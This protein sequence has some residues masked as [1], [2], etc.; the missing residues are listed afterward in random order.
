MNGRAFT[1][2]ETMLAALIGALVLA[3]CMGMF[4]LLDRS[5]RRLGA[6]YE[7]AMAMERLRGAVAR[8]MDTL[9]MSTDPLPPSGGR[10][11]TEMGQPSDGPPPP[12]PR[13]VL[14]PDAAASLVGVARRARIAGEGATEA[15]QRFEVVLSRS[16]LPV[17]EA[18]DIPAHE[19]RAVRGVFE[20][21]PDRRANLPSYRVK[22]EQPGWTLWWR[23]LPIPDGP[24]TGVAPSAGGAS[25]RGIE[26]Y[27]DP[28]ATEI[29]SG[30]EQCRWTVYKDRE[31]KTA[32]T[33][34]WGLNLPAYVELSV[35]TTAGLTANWMFEIGWT[36]APEVIADPALPAPNEA[37]DGG[38]ADGAR[39]AGN[40][41]TNPSTTADGKTTTGMDIR[42]ARPAKPMGGG[43]RRPIN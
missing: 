35:R 9:V 6:R 13:F 10:P 2:L 19:R 11:V 34:T 40:G 7:D 37:G 4:G 29:I 27:Q 15:P 12:P 14:E 23:P 41:A 18:V 26:P 16:P 36:N 22:G 39:G 21:R 3:A 25:T 28:A 31:K 24:T 1:L 20:L 42:P 8:T 17:R 30:L 33:A 38:D 43:G 32:Y 5:D